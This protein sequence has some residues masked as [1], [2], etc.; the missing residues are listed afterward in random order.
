MFDVSPTA[1]MV[2]ATVD[3]TDPEKLF[4]DACAANGI[5]PAVIRSARKDRQVAAVRRKVAAALRDAGCTVVEIGR[6]LNR[7]HS[8]VSDML[9]PAERRPA[10]LRA[11]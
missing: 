10:M 1:G 2:V 5:D 3:D 9:R 6:L 11:A 4:I 7:H 8:S